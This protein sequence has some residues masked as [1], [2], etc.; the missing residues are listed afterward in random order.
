MPNDNFPDY[1]FML[2]S[3]KTYATATRMMQD[4]WLKVHGEPLELKKTQPRSRFEEIVGIFS[5]AMDK[6]GGAPLKAAFE[7][8][9]AGNPEVSGMIGE[10]D[11]IAPQDR[12]SF[13]LQDME[14]VSPHLAKTAIIESVQQLT[15][16]DEGKRKVDLLLADLL[17]EAMRRIADSMGWSYALRVGNNRHFPRIWQWVGEVCNDSW[18]EKGHAIRVIA[19]KGPVPGMPSGPGDLRVRIDL[20]LL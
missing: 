17:R 9:A 7:K 14:H 10:M 4:A 3:V 5:M 6:A 20:R 2:G 13:L 15:I 18:T 11:K 16:Y 8:E 1:R 19:E 12:A